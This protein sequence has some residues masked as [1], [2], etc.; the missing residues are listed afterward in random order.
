MIAYKN[1]QKYRMQKMKHYWVYI[2]CSGRNGTL[3]VGVTSDIARRVYEH[4]EGLCKGFTSRYK[5]DRLV[6][7]EIFEQI[8]EARHREMCIKNWKRAWKLRLIESVNPEWNDLYE[9]LV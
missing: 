9:T 2:L 1:H 7:A 6:Y 4:K 5:V 3:Y 8:D